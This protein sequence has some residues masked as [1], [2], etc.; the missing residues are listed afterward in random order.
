[1]DAFS[2][3]HPNDAAALKSLM[4]IPGLTALTKKFMSVGYEKMMY[5]QM[6]AQTIRLSPNQLPRIYNHLPPICERLGI[7][8][9]ELF[10]LQQPDPNAFTYGDTKIFIT[11]TSGLVEM[12]SD[13]EL[14]A[15]LAHECGHI[16]CHHVLYRSLTR[17]ILSTFET[18]ILGDVAALVSGPLRFALLYWE[19]MSELSADRVAAVVTNPDAVI[20]MMCRLSGGSNNIISDVNY[21]EWINQANEYDQLKKDSKWDKM[22]QGFLTL[23]STHPFSAVRVREI[24]IWGESEEFNRAIHLPASGFMSSSNLVCPKCGSILESGWKYCLK[25]GRPVD[26]AQSIK[27]PSCGSNIRSDSRFCPECGMKL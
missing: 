6:L 18:G 24:K 19:R 20:K 14:D 2:F 17:F 23:G 9:P 25:C 11:V 7:P 26:N 8:I 13:E 3:I 4:A 1:M 12:A 15:V 21:D 27:C 16:L 10:L 5:G 22:L